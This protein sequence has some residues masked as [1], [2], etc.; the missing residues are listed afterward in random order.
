MNLTLVDL[1]PVLPAILVALTAFVVLLAGAF[2]GS[3]LAVCRN[4]ATAGLGAT[5]SLILVAPA[6]GSLGGTIAGGAYSAFVQASILVVAILAVWLSAARLDDDRVYPHEFFTLMLF[7]VVGMMGLATAEEAISLFVA[8]EIMSVALY[9]LCAMPRTDPRRQE[10]AIKYFITGAFSSAFLLFGIALLYG[11][12]G[13]TT[14]VL[15]AKGVA[16]GGLLA[17]MGAAFFFVGFLFK[18]GAAPFHMW[19]PDVYQGATTS[20]TAFMAA[21]V[22]IAAFGALGRVVAIT[23]GGL[24]DSWA[25][26]VALVAGFTMVV[27]NLGALAQTDLKRLLA[28]SSVAHA[29][30]MLAGIVGMSDRRGGLEALL[31]YVSTYAIT[32]LGAFGLLIAI[33]RNGREPALTTDLTG[34]SRRRPALA[35]MLTVL[36]I[37][38]TGV[39][40]SAGFVGKFHLFKAAVASGYSGLAAVGV[41]MSVVSAF[42]YLRLVVLMYMEE[43]QDDVEFATESGVV[44]SLVAFAAALTF[45]L[46]LF[47]GI[48]MAVARAAANSL[49]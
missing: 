15:M 1:Q 31:F 23:L 30:Y 38:L 43:P 34:L 47:P 4:I 45:G 22:K 20:V 14:L 40:V 11:A 16:D 19:S 18:V 13:S 49:F 42:Y 25:P 26:G 10:A 46:G 48:L 9:G 7:C 24:S 37:S 28:F 21:G 35:A 44:P 2:A 6:T 27:G 17:L 36:L 12:S 29:G 8:L 33:R 3:G 39:P 32:N 41:L 5:L